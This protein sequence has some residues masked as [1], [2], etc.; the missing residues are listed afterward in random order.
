MP[1]DAISVG[2]ATR[3]LEQQVDARWIMS[4][5]AGIADTNPRYLDTDANPVIAH[6]VFP[7]CL[8][9]PAILA[10]REL[11]GAQ[12]LSRDEAA[13]GVHTD[14]DLEVFRPITDGDRLR[15]TATL[16]GLRRIRPG[17]AQTYRLDTV[18]AD[19]QP[20]AR[21]YQIGILRDVELVGGDRVLEEFPKAPTAAAPW[22]EAEVCAV[23]IGP[24]A[25]HVYTECARIWNP[26]HTDLAVARAAGLPDLILHGSATL[27]YAVS[28]LVDRYLEGDPTRVS[29]VG[30]RFTAMVTM[31]SR[32][33]VH[34]RANEA[35]TLFFDILKDDGTPVFRGGFLRYRV[36]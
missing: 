14:H 20:V 6:P 7:V 32:L 18:D 22:P 21:T 10:G 29:R 13:R 3:P 2:E 12:R 25:A 27:A 11:P 1:A 36:D 8:E 16:V 31:P 24:A 15:T 33:E 4:Y 5:A 28:R 9:W 30:G 26:V 34:T 35:D 23:D 19:G 17:T